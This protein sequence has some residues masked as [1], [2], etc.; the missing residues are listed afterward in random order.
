M[1]TQTLEKRFSLLLIILYMFGA[2]FHLVEKTRPIMLL[3]TELMLLGGASVVLYFTYRYVR[4][5]I[6][7]L[8]WLAI[9]IPVTWI[10]EIVGVD[11]GLVFGQY[12]YGNTMRIQVFHVPLIIGINWA[13]L[14]L[15]THSLS[16]TITRIRWLR[17]MLAALYIVIFDIFMEPVAQ[18]LDYWQWEDQQIPLQ[19]YLAWAV[20]T[21]V[22]STMLES[23]K[24]YSRSPILR[25]Y[26]L[27]QLV[28][29]LVLYLA[30]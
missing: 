22:F 7:L 20:I 11:T 6:R 28:F 15:A 13:V 2:G 4:L 30:L 18:K 29:F 8:L 9:T 16:L 10:I 5:K 23:F 14:I 12:E 3:L 25:A 21:V 26:F 17:P 19:N 1:E 27:I 24:I